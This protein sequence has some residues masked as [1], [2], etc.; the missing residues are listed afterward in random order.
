MILPMDKPLRKEELLPSVLVSSTKK[1]LERILETIGMVSKLNLIEWAI[2][3]ASYSMISVSV[4][5]HENS[6]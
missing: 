4:V 6:R 3:Y 1:V 2:L 5:K